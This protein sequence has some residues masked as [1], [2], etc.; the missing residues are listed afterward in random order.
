[1]INRGVHRLELNNINC[2]TWLKLRGAKYFRGE[3][4]KCSPQLPKN[5]LTCGRFISTPGLIF[6]FSLATADTG[7]STKVAIRGERGREEGGGREGG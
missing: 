4:A 6:S 5:L 1:M 2:K 7:F 3:G